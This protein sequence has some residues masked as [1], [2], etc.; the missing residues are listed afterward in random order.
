MV[1]LLRLLL[2]LVGLVVVVA[3]AVANRES[4]TVSFWPLPFEFT[5]PLFA[6]FLI[7]LV[8]GVILGGVAHWLARHGRR[9]EYRQLR[10][11]V[12]GYEYRERMQEER[13]EAAEAERARERAQALRLAPAQRSA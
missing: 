8:V 2:A 6:V 9:V 3:F 12:A 11:R 13:L 10:R 4:V 1:K 7:G 5:L